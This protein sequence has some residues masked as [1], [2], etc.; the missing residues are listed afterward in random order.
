VLFRILLGDP[1]GDRQ[2]FAIAA[3][4][5]DKTNG[6]RSP[7]FTGAIPGDPLPLEVSG[8]EFLFLLGGSIQFDPLIFG[9]PVDILVN[10]RF[11]PFGRGHLKKDR[12]HFIGRL[13][14]DPLI[15]FFRFPGIWYFYR[16]RRL[17]LDPSLPARSCMG[18][19]TE[20]T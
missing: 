7:L 18:V 19:M 13:T 9:E 10:Q 3:I 14:C 17:V 6:S 16:N 2:H 1:I 5:E 20:L 15:C 8:F 4:G 11:Q 12:G